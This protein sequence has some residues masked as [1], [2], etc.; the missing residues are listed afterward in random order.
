MFPENLGGIVAGEHCGDVNLLCDGFY[1]Q[2]R[3]KSIID[4]THNLTGRRSL[5]V[6][7]YFLCVFA[8]FTDFSVLLSLILISYFYRCQ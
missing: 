2:I 3:V 1:R 8:F 4:H 7:V 5:Y 6:Y